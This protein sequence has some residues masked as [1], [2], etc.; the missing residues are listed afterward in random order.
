MKF[1]NEP[2]VQ[3]LKQAITIVFE[4]MINKEIRGF[5]Q[6]RDGKLIAQNI[7][8]FGESGTVLKPVSLLRL[9]KEPKSVK[10]RFNW[11]VIVDFVNSQWR[12]LNKSLTPLF[13]KEDITTE[14]FNDDY[15]LHL[16]GLLFLCIYLKK[17]EVFEWNFFNVTLTHSINNSKS[18][19]YEEY[20]EEIFNNFL[21]DTLLYV[22]FDSNSQF[23]RSME[24]KENENEMMKNFADN[25]LNKEEELKRVNEMYDELLSDN[26]RQEEELKMLREYGN[27]YREEANLNITGRK[28]VQDELFY[29]KEEMLN[30]QS[31]N[32]ELNNKFMT[33]QILHNR[34]KQKYEDI[35]VEGEKQKIIQI[36]LEQLEQDNESKQ[37]LINSL[38]RQHQELFD[39]R[40]QLQKELFEMRVEKDRLE[41]DY[42]TLTKK[43]VM[44]ERV[45]NHHEETFGRLPSVQR[46]RVQIINKILYQDMSKQSMLNNSLRRV[47]GDCEE[48]YRKLCISL[49]EETLV[50]LQEFSGILTGSKDFEE[51]REE[52]SK[53][54]RESLTNQTRQQAE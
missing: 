25:Y 9:E 24:Q 4:K 20:Y 40:K 50:Y 47:N 41:K 12:S 10:E 27:T 11:E 14:D 22:I 54:D 49:A 35:M 15:K 13:N 2:S 21:R 26:E 19:Y 42:Q 44:N 53:S 33:E 37:E 23:I 32:D 48:N 45:L 52:I 31:M 30:L 36:T 1:I 17:A 7:Q 28:E 51:N 5:E 18:N 6:L 38:E 34:Y 16:I 8:C 3:K 43:H 39:D 29:C 46:E